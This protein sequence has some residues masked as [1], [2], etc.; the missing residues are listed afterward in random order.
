[1]SNEGSGYTLLGFRTDE[2]VDAQRAAEPSERLRG[3]HTHHTE[4]L[5]VR[6]TLSWLGWGTNL[7]TAKRT[8]P[9]H[10]WSSGFPSPMR[11]RG[12]RFVSSDPHALSGADAAVFL[13]LVG[14]LAGVGWLGHALWAPFTRQLRP[15]VS[16]SPWDLP[17]Y[18]ARSLLRMFVALG[19][20]LV[21]TLAVANWRRDRR[22]RRG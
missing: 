15:V 20:S 8:K 11:S 17:Y 19:A 3:S 18:A 13:S 21:F 14:L 1:M 12:R 22:G 16:L 2:V 7:A 4:R 10:C 6:G 9:C 5:G